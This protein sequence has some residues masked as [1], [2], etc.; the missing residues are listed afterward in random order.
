MVIAIQSL[1][2]WQAGV[3][4][5][6]VGVDSARVEEGVML[7]SPGRA[8]TM[9]IVGVVVLVLLG[10]LEL[11]RAISGFTSAYEMTKLPP[12]MKIETRAA[13]SPKIS[14]RR[15]FIVSGPFAL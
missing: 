8:V 5:T 9:M 2:N 4:M 11:S 3:G 7:G 13:R 6:T 1:G 14:S 12:T 10:V 15:S